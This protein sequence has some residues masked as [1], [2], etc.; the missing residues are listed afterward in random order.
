MQ[1]SYF[2][3]S[4]HEGRVESQPGTQ[5]VFKAW[6]LKIPCW[7]FRATKWRKNIIVYKNRVETWALDPSFPLK[8]MLIMFQ[9]RVAGKEL[10][11]KDLQEKIECHFF[12]R[13]SVFVAQLS[14]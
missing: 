12:L 5:A 1:V 3:K 11:P 4:N 7:V 8:K 14:K 13:G 2:M 9:V 6:L 10:K